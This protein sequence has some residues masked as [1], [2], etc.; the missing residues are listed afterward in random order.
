MF[1]YKEQ[2]L[3]NH[4]QKKVYN[5]VSDIE[6]YPKFIPW[7]S[8][9]EFLKK[10]D[11]GLSHYKLEVKFSMFSNYFIT[12]DRF[13]P[14]QKIEIELVEGPFKFLNSN[15]EFIAK[16]ENQTLVDF[17]INF[18]FKNKL[19]SSLLGKVFLDAN[20]QVLHSFLDQLNK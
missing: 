15:W 16:G 11:E 14:H 18:D 19:I 13:T 20:K 1:E 2:V 7:C 5:L 6:S 9:A 10:D 4:A 12:K 8:N 3:V 17:Y